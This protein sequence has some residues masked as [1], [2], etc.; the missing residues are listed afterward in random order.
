MPD[1]NP[2]EDIVR[3]S[4]LFNRARCHEINEEDVVKFNESVDRLIGFYTKILI[5]DELSH[6]ER[7][8]RK[9]LKG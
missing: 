2:I 1:N 5:L 7:V 3:M 8:Y 6:N 9:E 4:S